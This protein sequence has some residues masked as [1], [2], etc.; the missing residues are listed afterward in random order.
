MMPLDTPGLDGN[1]IQ[2]VLIIKEN[3][4]MWTKRGYDYYHKL[5]II[6]WNCVRYS[7]EPLEGS[8]ADCHSR[9]RRKPPFM[10]F[11]I[12]TYFGL[13]LSLKITKLSLSKHERRRQEKSIFR[14]HFLIEQSS[15]S[16][17]L[18]AVCTVIF[19]VTIIL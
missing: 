13:N 6:M 5:T 4:K 12:V 15:C 2:C 9:I 11:L 1:H 10:E 8:F 14:D 16:F 19:Y 7:N 17:L 18:K 3:P